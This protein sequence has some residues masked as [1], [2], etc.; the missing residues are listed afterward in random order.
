MVSQISKA[1]SSTVT[2]LNDVEYEMCQN[3]ADKH[4]HTHTRS[5]DNDHEKLTQQSA[6]IS[7]RATASFIDSL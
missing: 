6:C 5:P 7:Q 3:R 4:T 2:P 1:T